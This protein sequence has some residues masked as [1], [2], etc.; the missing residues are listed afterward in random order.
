MCQLSSGHL[1]VSLLVDAWLPGLPEAVHGHVGAVVE[2]LHQVGSDQEAGPGGTIVG[3]HKSN[4]SMN[5]R[6]DLYRPITTPIQTQP[7]MSSGCCSR[8]F[9]HKDRN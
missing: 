9:C 8:Q 4:F 1:E 7:F 6:L 2:L 5:A 3:L